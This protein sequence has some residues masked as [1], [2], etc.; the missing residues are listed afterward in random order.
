ALGCANTSSECH[1]RSAKNERNRSTS[2]EVNMG[3]KS[4]PNSGNC[5]PPSILS[6]S[7]GEC[8]LVLGVANCGRLVSRANFDGLGAQD[9]MDSVKSGQ[10]GTIFRPD[11]PL[12][13]W[14]VF[15]NC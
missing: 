9:H 5:F 1:T 6:T 15:R 13:L 8:G 2:K 3:T 11:R 4:V 10:Y 14:P 12:D 7:S